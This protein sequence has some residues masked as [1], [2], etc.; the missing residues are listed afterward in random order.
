VAHW[1][2]VSGQGKH[3]LR[4][5]KGSQRQ[6]AK[7]TILGRKKKWQRGDPKLPE[8]RSALEPLNTGV[9]EEKELMCFTLEKVDIIAAWIDPP[10]TDSENL[11][12]LSAVATT[13]RGGWGLKTGYQSD[14]ALTW[15]RNKDC[16]LGEA[17]GKPKP[18]CSR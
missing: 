13:I 9:L 7:R 16:Q 4:W 2:G 3:K 6:T 8:G 17:H 18:Q 14:E 10:A 5:L 15:A 1:K 12:T 11:P